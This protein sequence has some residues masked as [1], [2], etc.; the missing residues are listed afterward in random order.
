[1]G[2]HAAI[3]ELEFGDP[4]P[5]VVGIVLQRY[6]VTR[7]RQ[8]DHQ[9][10]PVGAKADSQIARGNPCA[11]LQDVGAEL[12]GI[13]S[14]DV[15]SIAAVEPVGIDPGATDQRIIAGPAGQVVIAAVAVDCV[16]AP[17]AEQRIDPVRTVQRYIADCGKRRTSEIAQIERA[18]DH[19]FQPQ[20]HPSIFNPGDA[21]FG[22]QHQRVAAVSLGQYLAVQPIGYDD[23][24]A[25]A[26]SAGPEVRDGINPIAPARQRHEQ[27]IGILRGTARQFSGIKPRTDPFD[28]TK[29]TVLNPAC[30]GRGN[31]E[32]LDALVVA[33]AASG[34]AKAVPDSII[35]AK[36]VGNNIVGL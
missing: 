5:P 19:V 34:R 6:A 3:G 22:K 33:R 7:S 14:D 24:Q 4:R 18:R 31:R 35:S 29:R 25:I 9:I 30:G 10:A 23:V 17:A 32:D 13:I 20:Q 27:V 36:Q 12:V 1:M 8:T 21:G 15:L 16:I 2:Q 11:E 26:A 28:S